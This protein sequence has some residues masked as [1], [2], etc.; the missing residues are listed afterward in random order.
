MPPDEVI[1]E[2]V[3]HP[4]I[5]IASNIGTAIEMARDRAGSDGVIVVTGSLYLVGEARALLVE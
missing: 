1:R 2:A 4:C 3:P 5:G